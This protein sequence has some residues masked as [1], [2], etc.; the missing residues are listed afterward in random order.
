MNEAHER[1]IQNQDDRLDKIIK[2]SGQ[3]PYAGTNYI[4]AV[5]KSMLQKSI[6]IKY[7]Q[8]DKEL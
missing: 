5:K 3:P 4:N 7:L 1:D 8:N 6:T 2:L